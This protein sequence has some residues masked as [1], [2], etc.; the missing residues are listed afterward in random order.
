MEKYKSE[1]IGLNDF[2]QI[3]I[4]VTEIFYLEFKLSPL[5]EVLLSKELDN[6]VIINI[7]KYFNHSVNLSFQSEIIID[8]NNILVCSLE[9][10]A[11]F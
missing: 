1:I 8:N 5:N 11:C 3:Y 6:D 9:D 10:I 2:Y 4:P 7:E